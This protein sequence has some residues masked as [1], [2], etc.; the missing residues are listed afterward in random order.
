[1]GL[2]EGEILAL[3]GPNGAGKTTIIN[4][5]R[6]ELRPDSGAIRIRGTD[7]Q[8]EIRAAQQHLGGT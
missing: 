4:M 3:L 2:G 1:L 6:G 8:G 5:V 7:I